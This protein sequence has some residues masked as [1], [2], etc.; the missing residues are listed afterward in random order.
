M[1]DCSSRT[2]RT[3]AREEKISMSDKEERPKTMIC[4]QPKIT[5]FRYF[6]ISLEQGLTEADRKLI[7]KISERLSSKHEERVFAEGE[8]FGEFPYDCE[9]EGDEDGDS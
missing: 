5:P 3:P 9:D 7:D 2:L 1:E 6:V 8:S 4:A